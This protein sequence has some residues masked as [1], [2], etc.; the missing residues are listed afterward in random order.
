GGSSVDAGSPGTGG[1]PAGAGGSPAGAGGSP[2]G[3]GGAGGSPAG[4]GG[5]G[6]SAAGAGGAGG[7]G[8]TDPGCDSCELDQCPDFRTFGDAF[9]GAQRAQYDAVVACVRASSCHLNNT[10]DCYCGTAD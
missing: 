3:A 8:V 4:A 9:M 7:G 10:L 2:A 5:A 1:S 6:G